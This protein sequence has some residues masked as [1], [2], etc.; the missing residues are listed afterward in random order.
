MS[1]NS[2]DRRLV[3]AELEIVDLGGNH[4]SL[5]KDSPLFARYRIAVEK[6]RDVAGGSARP[7]ALGEG[8]VMFHV[9]SVEPASL[10]SAIMLD[11]NDGEYLLAQCSDAG[12]Y[13]L[14]R[15]ADAD[16]HET[17]EINGKKYVPVMGLD[18]GDGKSLICAG[19]DPGVIL[20]V[21]KEL[22][23]YQKNIVGKGLSVLASRMQEMKIGSHLSTLLEVVEAL[24]R[25]VQILLVVQLCQA[26][27]RWKTLVVEP[28]HQVRLKLEQ[29]NGVQMRSGRS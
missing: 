7:E 5:K 6:I 21:C 14:V 20:P 16:D 3:D 27:L 11:E 8:E 24:L 15:K 9:R 29:K 18:T 23:Y 13:R 17:I 19:Y 28:L 10:P 22:A 26:L 25:V 12:E 2:S 4:F 1:N